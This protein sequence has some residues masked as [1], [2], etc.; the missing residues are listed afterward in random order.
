[1]MIKIFGAA[2]MLHKNIRPSSSYALSESPE[3]GLAVAASG[4]M[5]TPLE[6]QRLLGVDMVRNRRLMGPLY[7]VVLQST[8]SQDPGC[9]V[10]QSPVCGY[11]IAGVLM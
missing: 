10:S 2:M 6:G 5:A 4:V 8:Y 7:W 3:S 11:W 9:P 1:M